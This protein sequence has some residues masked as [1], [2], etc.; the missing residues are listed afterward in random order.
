MS[1]PFVSIRVH[2][3]F[4]LGNE[5]GGVIRVPR[6]KLGA[7][8]QEP[9]EPVFR[10]LLDLQVYRSLSRTSRARTRSETMRQAVDHFEL[11]SLRLATPD[12]ALFQR[13]EG[14]T[15]GSNT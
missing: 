1:Q 15:R 3:W 10:F 4:S 5:N 6:S 7:P 14:A 9:L 12:V 11:N 8:T 13:L 2:S